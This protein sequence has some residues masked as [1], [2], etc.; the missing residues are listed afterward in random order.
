MRKSIGINGKKIC[1]LITF[2]A[3]F[4]VSVL[5]MLFCGRAIYINMFVYKYIDGVSFIQAVNFFLAFCSIGVLGILFFKFRKD[6]NHTVFFKFSLAL[7]FLNVAFA[8][9]QLEYF[10]QFIK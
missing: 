10:F 5:Q 4:S 9:I 2:M 6:V 7:L 1:Y 3:A 8:I